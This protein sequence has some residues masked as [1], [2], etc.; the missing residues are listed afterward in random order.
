MKLEPDAA[1]YLALRQKAGGNTASL[2]LSRRKNPATSTSKA[3]NT[4]SSSLFS[5][6]TN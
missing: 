5:S 3:H 1:D 6:Y 4:I 2:A